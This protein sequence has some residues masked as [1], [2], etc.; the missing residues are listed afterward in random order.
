RSAAGRKA[1]CFRSLRFPEA[2]HGVRLPASNSKGAGQKR[3]FYRASTFS[4]AALFAFV[5]V[6]LLLLVGK[7]LA[8]L[9]CDEARLATPFQGPFSGV[10]QQISPR[11]L[12][13]KD[14]TG[15]AI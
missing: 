10:C 12:F 11:D 2:C 1:A 14:P 8:G 15:Y 9:V 13:L 6:L 3:I 7:W 4:R 5:C